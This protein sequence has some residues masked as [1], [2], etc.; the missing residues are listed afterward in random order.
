[1]NSVSYGE[2]VANF[3]ALFVKF[4]CFAVIFVE[5][6][7]QFFEPNLKVLTN[8]INLTSKVISLTLKF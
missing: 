7:R 3:R 1:M 6:L 2:I 8:L 4:E 5:F